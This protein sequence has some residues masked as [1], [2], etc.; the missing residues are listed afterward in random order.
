MSQPHRPLYP[1][2]STC[3]LCSC[4]RV[5]TPAVT[6]PKMLFSLSQTKS[7]RSQFSLERHVP[8]VCNI[9]FPST[10]TPMLPSLPCVSNYHYLKFL[11]VCPSSPLE[12]KLHEKRDF[13]SFALFTTYPCSLKCLAHSRHSVV[14]W[15]CTHTRITWMYVSHEKH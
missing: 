2:A 9:A 4:L 7:F 15:K 12:C 1:D 3:P 11:F 5:F 8:P 13:I 6:L 10:P 14:E